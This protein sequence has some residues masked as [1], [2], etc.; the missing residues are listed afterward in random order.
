LL[1]SI[2]AVAAVAFLLP[3]TRD[4][5]AWRWAQAQ[6]EAPNY[7]DYFTEWSKGRHVIEARNRYAQ[8]QW[9]AT[10]RALIRQAYQQATHTNA[11]PGADAAY[12]KEQQL[13]REVFFWKQ[14]V[15]ANTPDSYK[16]YLDQYPRGQFVAQA[17]AQ[18]QSLSHPA[19]G[20]PAATN[21]PP[22]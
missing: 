9:A 22:Q 3:A 15:I 20:A 7:M 14:A 21:A 6:D 10:K 4:E 16:D 5:L 19:D 11:A 2:L 1:A 12:R 18:L 17:R 8:R 13:R